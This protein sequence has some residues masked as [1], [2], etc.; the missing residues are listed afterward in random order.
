VFVVEKNV[1]LPAG[2]VPPVWVIEHEGSFAAGHEDEA[3]ERVPVSSAEFT[4][5][6]DS[7]GLWEL[8]LIVV[9]LAAPRPL[10][11]TIEPGGYED[12][13]DPVVPVWLAV[14]AARAAQMGE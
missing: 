4:F 1:Q 12:Y 13:E 7:G 14:L 8:V 11:V 6:R 5:A 9:H 3:F 10:T 2:P